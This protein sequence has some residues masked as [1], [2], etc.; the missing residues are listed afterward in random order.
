MGIITNIFLCSDLLVTDITDMSR[1]P[2]STTK[3]HNAHCTRAKTQICEHGKTIPE[4]TNPQISIMEK[5]PLPT[6]RLLSTVAACIKV[7]V[8]WR[9]VPLLDLTIIWKSLSKLHI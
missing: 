4:M 5:K 8:D 7:I 2:S 9:R 6:P 3:M 1:Q